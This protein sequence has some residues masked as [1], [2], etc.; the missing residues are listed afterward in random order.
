MMEQG[1][2]PAVGEDHQW[3]FGTRLAVFLDK[4]LACPRKVDPESLPLGAEG[5]YDKGLIIGYGVTSAYLM[6]R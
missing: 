5:D 6:S 2:H 1:M 3:R 4:G